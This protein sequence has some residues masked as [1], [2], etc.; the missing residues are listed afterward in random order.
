MKNISDILF[1]VQA[2]LSST[3]VPG[4]MLRKFG[5]NSNLCE[6]CLEKVV[7]SIIPPANFY[8]SVY[9]EKL[10]EVGK[11]MGVQIY[12]R[13]KQSAESEGTPLSQIY[14]WHSFPYKYIILVSACSPFLTV[15]TIN[16]FI[17][18]FLESSYDGL[19]A[20]HERKTYFWD[21]S[22][23]CITPFEPDQQI[24]NTKLI[25]NPLLEASHNLYASRMDLIPQGYFMGDFSP[26]KP[27]LFVI[28]EF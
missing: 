15:A 11:N 9:E 10:K 18:H 17:Q 19:F 7:L 23:K 13:S 14:E 4:K 22:G 2:R 3:R 26:N 20:V 12:N 8:F 6:I 5:D 24:M 28:D 25:Q 27:E 1:I 21:T 16:K